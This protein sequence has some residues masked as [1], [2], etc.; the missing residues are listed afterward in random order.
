MKLGMFMMPVNDHRR[1]T[2]T[3]LKEDVELA[4]HCD[5]LGFD[6]FWVGEHYTTLSEPVTCPFIFL[7]NLIARTDK[8][9]LGTAVVNLPQ[10]HPVQ[11]AAHAAM[12][13]HLS[14]G[15]LLLGVS[16]G[17]LVSD[18]EMFGVTDQQVRRE[19]ASE[20]IDMVLKLWTTT[21]PYEIYGKY[22][23][24]KL[25]EHLYPDLGVGEVIKPY[26]RPHPPLVA[27]AMSPHSG[28]VRAAALK[29]WG[30]ISAN[31]VPAETVKTHWDGFVA[32]CE[33][34]GRTPAPADWRV[35]RSIFVG[36]DD[37]EAKAYVRDP[38]G[39][40]AHYFGYLV[41]LVKRA[42]FHAIMK[43]DPA[44]SDDE[45]TPDYACSN[46]VIAG[47]AASVA[48]QILALRE[49]VGPFGT[50]LATAADFI[51]ETHK[52]KLLES[53]ALLAQEVMPKVRA[54]LA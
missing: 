3:V 36:R 16:P 51:D 45:L 32:G 8:V 17:G 43:R 27:S 42:E 39:P 28:S 13:D 25:D 19:M 18:F 44:M 5:R 30:V 1:E 33:E 24:I 34:V 52:P 10:R 40:F 2:H 22:W 14:D 6:E 35:A 9:K 50:I 49:E 41:T 29:G 12:L 48:A 26:Q 53:M 31:F 46:F 38:G 54:G 15:R 47:D 4:V 7:A 37:A 11:T 23:T 21:P 20:A